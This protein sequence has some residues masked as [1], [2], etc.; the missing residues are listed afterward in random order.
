MPGS[1]AKLE[2]CGS[3]MVHSLITN[4]ALARWA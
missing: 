1:V 3:T 4:P 2:V